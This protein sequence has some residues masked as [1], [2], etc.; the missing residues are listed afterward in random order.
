MCISNSKK[1]C[2]SKKGISATFFGVRMMKFDQ[3]YLETHSSQIKKLQE[4]SANR[5]KN[6]MDCLPVKD[7]GEEAWFGVIFSTLFK[8][9]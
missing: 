6:I 2:W 1:G 8:L 3:N 5:A 9:S 4:A 7:L